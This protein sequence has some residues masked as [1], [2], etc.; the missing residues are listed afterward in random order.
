MLL[1][2][3]HDCLGPREGGLSTGLILHPRQLRNHKPGRGVDVD[4][5]HDARLLGG[6]AVLRRIEDGRGSSAIPRNP[7][8]K[9][10]Q[11]AGRRVVAGNAGGAGGKEH[12]QF[13]DIFQR[14]V[15]RMGLDDTF[16][17]IDVIA[18]GMSKPWRIRR[19]LTPE[20]ADALAGEMSRWRLR[21]PWL[22]AIQPVPTLV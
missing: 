22:G 5:S 8:G 10:Q 16:I 13:A 14:P 3:F 21:A 19:D 11:H 2:V 7:P 6:P 20:F 1:A 15:R 9:V 12:S 4:P 17:R 18:R